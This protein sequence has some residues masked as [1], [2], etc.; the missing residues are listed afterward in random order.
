MC[1][2]HA[3]L[4]VDQNLQFFHSPTIFNAPIECGTVVI[5]Q[6]SLLL[7]KL[8]DVPMRELKK[9]DDRCC[10]DKV[11]ASDRQTDIWTEIL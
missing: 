2:R 8:D 1:P 5:L 10:F 6:Q 4:L 9:S 3:K 7:R 11:L